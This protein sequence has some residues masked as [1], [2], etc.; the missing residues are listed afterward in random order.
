SSP[1]RPVRS[2]AISKHLKGLVLVGICFALCQQTSHAQALYAQQPDAKVMTAYADQ[3]FTK[4]IIQSEKELIQGRNVY[5]GPDAVIATIG[6]LLSRSASSYYYGATTAG[7]RNIREGDTVSLEAPRPTSVSSAIKELVKQNYTFEQKNAAL[8]TAVQDQ[9]ALIDRGTLNE[10]R[11]RDIYRVYDSSD[12]YKGMLE[13]HGLGDLQSSGKLYNRLADFHR[14]AASVRPGD[15]VIF[16]GQRKLFALGAMGGLGFNTEQVSGQTERALTA[17]LLWDV[18][19]PDG[20]GAEILFGGAYRGVQKTIFPNQ[21]IGGSF[22]YSIEEKRQAV[23]IAPFWIKKNIFYPSIISPFVAAGFS[24]LS[25]EHMYA[26]H[27][28]SENKRE[29]KNVTTVVPVLGAGIEF[30]PGRFFRP[31]VEMRWYDG[32]KITAAGSAYNTQSVFCSAGFMT[33]W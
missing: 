27:S 22:V 33:A 30:F 18:T 1:L 21:I 14:D 6:S 31:R 8:V 19:F 28:S 10:V 15:R 29:T 3:G 32:P 4:M 23:F 5:V 9:R 25:A 26:Y 16:V 12:H 7:K 20:W 17:G 13:I 2:M 24:L 11:E